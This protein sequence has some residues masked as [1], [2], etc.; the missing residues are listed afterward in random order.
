MSADY[1]VTSELIKL[2][3]Y[4]SRGSITYL[5]KTG[6]L[7]SGSSI[8]VG[9]VRQK[10]WPRTQLPTLLSGRVQPPKERRDGSAPLIPE[11]DAALAKLAHGCSARRPSS[12]AYSGAT[13]AAEIGRR[14]PQAAGNARP[15]R[16]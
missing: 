6:K 2:L 14:E 15:A 11:I 1:V 4:S 3:R 7:P 16:E 5:V 9:G 8:V 10:A 12:H 13:E